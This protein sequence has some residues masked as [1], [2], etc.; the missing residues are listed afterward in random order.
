MRTRRGARWTPSRNAAKRQRRQKYKNAPSPHGPARN[1]PFH[2][3]MDEQQ[4]AFVEFGEQG[5]PKEHNAFWCPQENRSRTQYGMTVFFGVSTLFLHFKNAAARGGMPARSARARILTSITLCFGWGG[6][7][8]EHGSKTTGLTSW[9]KKV[10]PETMASPAYKSHQWPRTFFWSNRA[11]GQPE[12][13]EARPSTST[14]PRF[15][16]GGITEPFGKRSD[17]TTR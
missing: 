6:D 16:E 3:P 7:F 12:E 11:G 9:T 17:R 15:L 4:F 1:G 13:K 2:V 14:M 10:K 5:C 8:V